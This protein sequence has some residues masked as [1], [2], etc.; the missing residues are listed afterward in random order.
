MITNTE[1]H[2]Q[3]NVFPGRLTSFDHVVDTLTFHTDN[4]VILRLQVF[5]DSVIRFKYGT[6][7]KLEK[8]FSYA[9]EATSNRGYNKLSVV[10]KDAYYEVNTS[11]IVCHIAKSDLR[12]RIFDLNGKIIC[13][14]ELG[15]HY[16]ESYE[17]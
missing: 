9:V 7:G 17:Y 16:E 11:K 6:G 13:E 15:F 10:E 5:R 8:D 2:S 3:G 4:G 1:L 14:D 12:S